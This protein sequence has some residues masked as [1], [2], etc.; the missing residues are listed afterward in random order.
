[1]FD[2]ARYFE[3]APPT[4]GVSL[5]LSGGRDV[6]VGIT[7][8][9]DLWDQAALGRP[10]YRHDPLAEVMRQGARVILNIAASPY[11]VGKATVK[12]SLFVRQAK[13][14]GV[15]IVYVNQVG[16]NDELSSTAAVASSR[17]RGK[18]SPAPKASRRTC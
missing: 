13:R 7:I 8:C 6:P 11:Q 14:A 2:E 5:T 1:M 3:A 18:S 12:E 17:R 4:G 9:E 15:P 10:L 16:G